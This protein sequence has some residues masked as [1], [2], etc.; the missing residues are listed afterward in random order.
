MKLS[1]NMQ[2]H[3]QMLQEALLVKQEAVDASRASRSAKIKENNWWSETLG[4][5][6]GI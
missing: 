2:L 1:D 6:T 5:G 4:L 3:T